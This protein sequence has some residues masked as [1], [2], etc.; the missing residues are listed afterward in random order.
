MPDQD[1]IDPIALIEWMWE[2]VMQQDGY[3]WITG[4]SDDDLTSAD[5]LELYK[6]SLKSSS[7]AS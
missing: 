2:N 5:V 7:N 1:H 6:K 4:T 3:R